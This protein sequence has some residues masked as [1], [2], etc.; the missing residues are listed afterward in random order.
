[1]LSSHSFC[2]SFAARPT[3]DMVSSLNF[4]RR[5]IQTTPSLLVLR[6]PNATSAKSHV[7]GTILESLILNSRICLPG[8]SRMHNSATCA[9]GS[10]PP[11]TEITSFLL[12]WLAHIV[13]ST[14]I[15][16]SLPRVPK[17][18]GHDYI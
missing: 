13:A 18:D 9:K 12:D 6:L 7:I 1:M 3:A 11:S 10:L 16:S 4:C 17:A 8:E 14:A 2:H 5:T 15:L